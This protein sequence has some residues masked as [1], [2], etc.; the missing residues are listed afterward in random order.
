MKTQLH[1][2]T[3]R[4]ATKL[5]AKAEDIM[6]YTLEGLIHEVEPLFTAVYLST[7]EEALRLRRLYPNSD[8]IRYIVS[9]VCVYHK[10]MAVLA[11]GVANGFFDYEVGYLLKIAKESHIAAA[12]FI[13]IFCT[14]LEHAE[15]LGL[16]TDLQESLKQ[17]IDHQK[18]LDGFVIVYA[19]KENLVLRFAKD[20]V[21]E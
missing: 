14:A 13:P 20:V 16:S 12:R 5:T 6:S 15:E 8:E 9:E 7:P 3:V 19:T 2:N 10:D 1:L 17:H 21:P 18:D 4:T 11:R